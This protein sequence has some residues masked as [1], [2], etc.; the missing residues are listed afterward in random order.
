MRIGTA[1]AFFREFKLKQTIN[2]V[3][4]AGYDC[5]EIWADHMR[6]Q[7]DSPK[8]VYQL[9]RE[10]GLCLSLHGP[11]YDLNPLSN[12]PGIRQESIKQLTEALRL[13]SE[14]EVEL[15]VV[16]PGRFSSSWDTEELF[17]PRLVDFVSSL[18]TEARPL[19]V[20]LSIELMEVRAK[21]FFQTPE[22]AAKLMN[23]NIPGVGIT[24]DIAHFYTLGDEV[25]LLKQIN[26]KWIN[27]VHLSD[28]GAERTHLPLGQGE[29]DIGAVLQTLPASYD[30][31][32]NIE[33]Y[34]PGQGM[35]IV[36]ANID[37]LRGLLKN[38]N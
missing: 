3:A 5:L 19:G 2:L 14:L 29:V 30:G 37:Y 36:K 11:S 10:A 24:V 20:E 18:A 13:A 21:E 6:E 34:I 17:F 33:G 31:I 9:A 25:A 12:N 7:G 15:M 16:H 1:S 27:H 35:D 28:S 22:D 23:N 26:P 38:K 4:E 8:Q 32:I